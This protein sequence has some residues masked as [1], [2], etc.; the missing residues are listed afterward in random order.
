MGRDQ[1]EGSYCS[2][3]ILLLAY[4]SSSLAISQSLARTQLPICFLLR[5]SGTVSPSHRCPFS[6]FLIPYRPGTASLLLREQCRSH[7]YSARCAHRIHYCLCPRF[8]CYPYRSW[9]T[10][11]LKRL[12]E[13]SSPPPRRHCLRR[14]R[15]LGYALCQYDQYPFKGQSRRCMVYPGES[16]EV[17]QVTWRATDNV[18]QFNDGM[19]AMSLLVPMVA[20]AL[21]FWVIGSELDFSIW[22]VLLAGGIM[23]L[24][25]GLMHYSAAFKLPYLTVSYTVSTSE[26]CSTSC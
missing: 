4:I 14:V 22:R 5:T 7:P 18:D 3:A 21:S 25:V 10:Y 17:W 15:H 1:R 26:S 9:S 24:T 2:M 16:W 6:Q 12:E 20:T 11:L 8:L 13:P 23:G 19:T